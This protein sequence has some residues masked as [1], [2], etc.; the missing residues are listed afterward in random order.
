LSLKLLVL[1]VTQ[2]CNLACE[3]CYAF[4]GSAE[5]MPIDIALK[6]V[7]L[8]VE[9][10]EALKIQFTGGE[11][12]LNMDCIEAV[13]RFGKNT[14]RKLIMSLQTN[15]TL[16]TIENCNKLKAMDIAIGVSIDGIGALN[17]LRKY[18]DG[19]PSFNDT[20]EGIINLGNCNKKCNLM[21]VVTS[22]NT[23]SLDTLLDLS[24]YLGNVYG[25]GLDIFRSMGRG[26]EKNLK[27][28]EKEMN[29]GVDALLNKYEELHKL[30]IPIR[31]KELERIKQLIKQ[32][33]KKD[34]Y[35]YA[36][37]Q[38]S[39]AVDTKGNLY[40]CS[41]FVCEEHLLGNLSNFEGAILSERKGMALPSKCES[42]NII[43]YCS[44][45]CPAN[46]EKELICVLN[47]KLYAYV[48][49]TEGEV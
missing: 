17:R 26:K 29:V 12:L 31:I 28:S 33:Q 34:L 2:R 41:S 18:P 1:R 48:N 24:F 5:N 23:Q 10:G 20:I 16:L 9:S 4:D 49:K 35:C 7:E 45:G 11:P 3:Y 14:K 30:N 38:C 8:A 19:S 39:L 36:Q 27:A 42:C 22:V 6:A 25:I 37:T 44:G 43:N 46:P 40:P 32:K 13:Y 47:K 21:S 15:G